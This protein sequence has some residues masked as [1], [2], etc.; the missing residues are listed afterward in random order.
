MKCIGDWW[1]ISIPCGAIRSDFILLSISALF[2]SIPCGA[3][4]SPSRMPSTSCFNL[5][6]FLVV[7]LEGYSKFNKNNLKRRFQFLVVR[8]EANV[9]GNRYSS[10]QFQFLV[11]RLE[12][13]WISVPGTIFVI[14]IPCGTIRRRYREIP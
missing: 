5:F 1:I 4:R 10:A 3:I 2:I 8:L 7:R 12:E 13:K 11:V 14:S 6:Q 9:S